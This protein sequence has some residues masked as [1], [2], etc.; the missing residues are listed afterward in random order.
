MF[1]KGELCSSLRSTM[2][3]EL[4]RGSLVLCSRPPLPRCGPY[5][6]ALGSASVM[7]PLAAALPLVALPVLPPF[8]PRV[9]YS[10]LLPALPPAAV[11]P[12]CCPSSRSPRRRVAAAAPPR[13]AA[14]APPLAAFIEGGR[15]GL[16]GRFAALPSALGRH[17]TRLGVV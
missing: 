1:G 7:P 5:E 12:C 3:R 6:P 2:M 14:A 16:R 9:L 17:S 8:C 13:A 11:A 4:R 10:R 15:P